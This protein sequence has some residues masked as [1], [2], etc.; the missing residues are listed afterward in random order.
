MMNAA[1][2]FKVVIPARYGSTRLPCKPLLP[3]A[4]KPMIAHVCERA[5]ESCAS[6]VVVATDDERIGQAACAAG[7]RVVMT[8]SDHNSGTE[9]IAEAVGLCGWDRSVLVVNLQGDEPLLPPLLIQRVAEALA[10]QTRAGAATLAVPIGDVAELSN[11]NVVK[12]VLD[13]LGYAL[14][15]SRAPI[16]WDRESFS[17]GSFTIRKGIPFLRHIGLYAYTV[18]FLQR[19][20]AWPAA[21]LESAESLEQLRILWNGAS[22]FVAFTGDAPPAGIDTEQDL[23][24]AA[25]LLGD[26]AT[27]SL[28][29]GRNGAAT[30]L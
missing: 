8:H 6:E 2:D 15:F 10:G 14:Y 22:I 5:L 20:V 4:G 17:S 18:G 19:Y 11:P 26:G 16:P 21:P 24:R 1:P 27:K 13:R 30:V 12:V 7:V 28:P 25:R 29:S 23:E 9:R 3:I